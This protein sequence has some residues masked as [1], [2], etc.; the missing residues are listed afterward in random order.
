LPTSKRLPMGIALLLAGRQTDGHTLRSW[1]LVSAQQVVFMLWPPPHCCPPGRSEGT[2]LP[3]NT[4]YWSSVIIWIGI[5]YYHCDAVSFDEIVLYK[6]YVPSRYC[7]VP[8]SVGKSF[9]KVQ[10][11]F[12]ML[13]HGKPAFPF[14]IVAPCILITY[15]FLWPTN[16]LYYT[17]KTLKHTVKISCA[18]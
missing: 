10:L 2:F 14:F 3:L 15:R 7:F 4:G 6:T 16:A 13:R 1:R 18:H 11:L 12:V 5:D 9:D 17:Y 8:Y